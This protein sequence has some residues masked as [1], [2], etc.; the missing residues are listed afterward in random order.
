MHVLWVDMK[1]RLLSCL[2]RRESSRTTS[3][4][5]KNSTY[6]DKYILVAPLGKNGDDFSP[7]DWVTGIAESE[8]PIQHSWTAT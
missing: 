1:M 8:I 3:K 6:K 7:E 5:W 4:V 2:G